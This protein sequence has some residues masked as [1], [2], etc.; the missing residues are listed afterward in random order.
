MKKKPKTVG[1]YK[2]A[3]KSG[4]DNYRASAIID[5]I[6]ELKKKKIKVI[7]YDSSIKEKRIFGC[8]LI[9]DLN[10]FKKASSVIIANR[11]NNDLNSVKNKVFTKDL[12]KRD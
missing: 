4:S 3:M 11:F 12:Y 2:L 6:K 7:I 5:V 1:V 10:E 8:E 9:N